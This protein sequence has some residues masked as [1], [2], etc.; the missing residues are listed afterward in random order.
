MLPGIAFQEC[1][2]LGPTRPSL[3]QWALLAAALSYGVIEWL[4]LSRSRLIDRTAIH[5]GHAGRD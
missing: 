1:A 3:T 4:A 5:R 2:M